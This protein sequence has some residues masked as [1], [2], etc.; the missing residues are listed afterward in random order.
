MRL[1]SAQNVCKFSICA[2]R[3]WGHHHV[4]ISQVS[5]PLPHPYFLQNNTRS[6]HMSLPFL[7]RMAKC[8][9]SPPHRL[10]SWII[11]SVRENPSLLCRGIGMGKRDTERERER[12]APPKCEWLA[13]WLPSFHAE[14]Y[15][16]TTTLLGLQESAYAYYGTAMFSF[17]TAHRHHHQCFYSFRSVAGI[18]N[19]YIRPN[20]LFH[21]EM[22][23]I[24][25]EVESQKCRLI[26][27]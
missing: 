2:I 8:L 19:I 11:Q 10:L 6:G 27:K 3:T 23:F 9:P 24:S 22:G 15:T 18:I 16:N 5:L 20:Y 12:D 4:V 13:V 17:R 14:Y 21:W 26:I 25:E 1:K 7:F